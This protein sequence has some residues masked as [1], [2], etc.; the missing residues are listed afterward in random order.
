MILTVLEDRQ[1]LNYGLKLPQDTRLAG[2]EK[3]E[4]TKN[5]LHHRRST[6]TTF[7][8]EVNDDTKVV[9][10]DWQLL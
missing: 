10:V 7:D 5:G 3:S 2:D 1:V 4:L 6:T 9:V 8:G